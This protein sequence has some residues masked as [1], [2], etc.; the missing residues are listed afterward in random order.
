MRPGRAAALRVL[1]ET[2]RGSG[3]HGLRAR[4]AALPRLVRA[5]TSGSYRGWDR[6][7]VLGLM[8]GVV[9]VVSPV[10]LVPEVLLGFFGLAD[11]ALVAAW[12]AGAVL[13]EVDGFLDWENAERK[14]VRGDVLR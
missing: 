11:D 9:Y 13:A 6:R 1:L 4:L 3:V 5:A 7:R 2:L 8:V 12:L 14:V 10:D